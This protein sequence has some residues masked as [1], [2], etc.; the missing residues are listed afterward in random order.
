[1]QK[2]LQ[3]PGTPLEGECLQVSTSSH[4][5]R[6]GSYLPGWEQSCSRMGLKHTESHMEAQLLTV[7]TK[8]VP[9]NSPMAPLGF[10]FPSCERGNNICHASNIAER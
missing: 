4:R 2:R 9:R 1:M 5:Q 3:M 10:S 7:G 6:E 8:H